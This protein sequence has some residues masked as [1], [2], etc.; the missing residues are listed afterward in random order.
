MKLWFFPSLVLVFV[1][2]GAARADGTITV[3]NCHHTVL[4]EMHGLEKVS[5]D[6]AIV[7]PEIKEHCTGDDGSIEVQYYSS[8]HLTKSGI[9]ESAIYDERRKPTGTILRAVAEKSRCPVQ[10][11]NKYVQTNALA[12]DEFLAIVQYWKSLRDAP[13]ILTSKIRRNS[14]EPSE[15][16]AMQALAEHLRTDL[17]SGAAQNRVDRTFQ[18]L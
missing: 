5:L 14:A 12:D 11:I 2:S 15:R 6:G 4:S 10:L 17:T 18:R 8:V 3:L 9:C 1:L 13:N 7:R 16:V